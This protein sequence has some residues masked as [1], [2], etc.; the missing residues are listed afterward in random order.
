LIIE[1]GLILPQVA[2]EQRWDVPTFI[3]NVCR[4]AGL[5]EGAWQRST[6]LLGFEAEVF[7]TEIRVACHS[8]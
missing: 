1:K 5:L 8:R 6:K 3:K 2:K 7:R 4:K